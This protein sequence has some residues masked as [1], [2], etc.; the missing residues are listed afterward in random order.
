VSIIGVGPEIYH[1]D[2]CCHLPGRYHVVIYQC[3]L[4]PQFLFRF[5]N[6][7]VF[8]GLPEEQIHYQDLIGD[9]D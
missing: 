6:L 4:L 1:L 7:L 9:G 8:E 2:A 5:F 3:D